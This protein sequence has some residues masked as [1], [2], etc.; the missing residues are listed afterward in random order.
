VQSI[1]TLLNKTLDP[2]ISASAIIICN[3]N[4]LDLLDQLD[5]GTGR[6]LLQPDPT[7]ATRFRVQGRE[8]VPVP[9]SLLADIASNTQTPY[10]V[11]D[12]HA[13]LTHFR[14]QPFEMATTNIGGDAWRYNNTEVRGI[15]RFDDVVFDD[16]AMY[17]LDVT[18]P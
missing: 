16:L 7:S 3:Q 4:G 5:D 17:C 2:A 10:Y 9:T 13:W 11:G 15:M 18:L 8:V 1:K 12:G 14:R 6:P